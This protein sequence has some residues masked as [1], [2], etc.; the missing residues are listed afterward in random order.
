MNH[1]LI[2]IKALGNHY[3]PS[4]YHYEP[5]IN[6]FEPSINHYEP[7]INHDAPSIP[8]YASI[9]LPLGPSVI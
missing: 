9:N 4:I 6:H 2:I 3:E 8:H 7:S 5:S 1:Q